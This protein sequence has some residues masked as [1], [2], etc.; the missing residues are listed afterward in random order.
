[1]SDDTNYTGFP[2]SLHVL[3]IA[4]DKY[5][6]LQQI[7]FN[8]ITLHLGHRALAIVM[9][10]RDNIHNPGFHTPLFTFASTTLKN[11]TVILTGYFY[12]YKETLI[13]L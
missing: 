4:I 8:C 6:W 12:I 3:V 2:I 11:D 13:S 1:M 9:F 10:G 5:V 7:R